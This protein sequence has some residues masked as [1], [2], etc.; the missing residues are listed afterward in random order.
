MIRT[1]IIA[2]AAMAISL[3]ATA[4]DFYLYGGASRHF[5]KAEFDDFGSEIEIDDAW[6][7][8]IAFGWDFAAGSALEILI[9]GAS[10]EVEG[11]TQEVA[12]GA[13]SLNLYF[14]PRLGAIQPRIGVGVGAAAIDIEDSSEDPEAGLM[15]QGSAGLMLWLGDHFAL[16][17]TYRYRYIDAPI[18]GFDA[19]T[20][21]QIVEVGAKV[22]F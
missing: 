22:S 10:G 21:D 19:E 16:G 6:G 7:G 12:S 5:A 13:I 8:G 20:R 14:A 17:P 4:A 18:N 15:A 2:I 3:P 9:D 11:G 1:M